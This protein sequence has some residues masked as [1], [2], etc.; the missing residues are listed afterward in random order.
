MK[1]MII[2]V[3]FLFIS[4]NKK[5]DNNAVTQAVVIPSKSMTL[6]TKNT[7]LFVEFPALVVGKNSRFAAHFTI[8]DKH[9]PV[10]EGEVTVSLIKGDKGIRNTVQ[11]PSSPGI[12]SPG[13]ACHFL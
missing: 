1:Y 10:R 9:Q 8:L 4:C 2:L 7:E 5:Q 11:S 3:A 12:F 6:W 13:S